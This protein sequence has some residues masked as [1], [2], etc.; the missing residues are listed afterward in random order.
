MVP[1]VPDTT[2]VW[3]PTRAVTRQDVVIDREKDGVYH[4]YLRDFAD[5]EDQRRE[6][7]RWK[8]LRGRRDL[9]AELDGVPWLANKVFRIWFG[10]IAKTGREADGRRRRVW[11]CGD[12]TTLTDA[13]VQKVAME[14]GATLDRWFGGNHET[15]AGSNPLMLQLVGDF[16]GTI[17]FASRCY[18]MNGPEEDSWWEGSGMHQSGNKHGPQCLT[19]GIPQE[20][21]VGL[22]LAVD[23]AWGEETAALKPVVG[24]T[25]KFSDF[26]AELVF[27]ERGAENHSQSR[28]GRFAT[29]FSLGERNVPC[30][31][32][33][34]FFSE[35][36]LTNF[37][38]PRVTDRQSGRE[39]LS[40]FTPQYIPTS[41]APVSM[42]NVERIELI[43]RN[44]R[45]RVVF[46]IEHLP[47]PAE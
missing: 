26:T 27:M 1:D 25:A 18:L 29:S 17:G 8:P 40:Y 44:H 38:L 6:S 43:Y 5:E 46:P 3:P 13:E 37:I 4:L 42:E 31:T 33:A 14:H 34:F 2:V 47:L 7:L 16:E 21:L 28:K 22:Q 30:T 35:Q 45:R 10:S 19:V 36:G 15:M 32:F 41:G 24:A 20:S 12:G 11:F 9:C 39:H 23:L